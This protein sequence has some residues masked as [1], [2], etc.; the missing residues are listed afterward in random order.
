[1]SSVQ[2]ATSAV[3][4]VGFILNIY[5]AISSIKERYKLKE[6]RAE[7]KKAI[8]DYLELAGGSYT[9]MW[10]IFK[11]IA[12]GNLPVLTTTHRCLQ[13]TRENETDDLSLVQWCGWNQRNPHM[14]FRVTFNMKFLGVIPIIPE[15][16][17]GFSVNIHGVVVDNT[18]I[19]K[20]QP[21]LWAKI[22]VEGYS[23]GA[24]NNNVKVIIDRTSICKVR[25]NDIKLEV[26]EDA[27]MEKE[28]FSDMA[29][30]TEGYSTNF[31]TAI[32]RNYVLDWPGRVTQVE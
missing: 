3:T 28:V 23:Y 30:T 11:A 6:Q 2:L 12:K 29:F 15:D 14:Y 1:M 9:D 31:K 21:N 22:K 4:V 17:E 8:A 5:G 16:G 20:C 24:I 13:Y 27:T 10:Q 19:E 25:F 18:I 32:G 26:F 7:M